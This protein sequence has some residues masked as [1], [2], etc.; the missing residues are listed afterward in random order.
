MCVKRRSVLAAASIQSQSPLKQPWKGSDDT[1]TCDCE[2]L[3]QPLM[4]IFPSH[5]NS[6]LQ[7]IASTFI[8]KK[9]ISLRDPISPY[10]D[11]ERSGRFTGKVH[12]NTTHKLATPLD[13]KS[14]AWEQSSLSTPV[15]KI[16][17]RCLKQITIVSYASV[18]VTTH[19]SGGGGT[20]RASVM[21]LTASYT[22]KNIRAPMTLVIGLIAGT[23][24]ARNWMN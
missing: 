9:L 22:K 2:S 24:Q 7:N 17:K 6:E 1:L 10:R 15:D 20:W 3:A 13:A 16:R 19:N 14:N 23:N 21:R 4:N 12:Q 8:A 11:G 18:S 5:T